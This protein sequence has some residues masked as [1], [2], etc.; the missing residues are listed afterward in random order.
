MPANVSSTEPL[1]IRVAI[2]ED[3]AVIRRSL[4]QIVSEAR[5]LSCVATCATAEEGLKRLPH[6]MP[7]VVLMEP[8]L[9]QPRGPLDDVFLGGPRSEKTFCGEAGLLK[10]PCF[11]AGELAN[12]QPRKMDLAATGG[13]P[14]GTVGANSTS[15]WA[16][17]SR[18]SS[19]AA[20]ASQDRTVKIR[21]L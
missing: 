2:V 16:M 6:L 9:L 17:A 10:G 20:V 3:D 18:S 1:L 12:I 8:P 19:F 13:W 21:F 14:A 5:G 4:S 15:T 11:T 7:D